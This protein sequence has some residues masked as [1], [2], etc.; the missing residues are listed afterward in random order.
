MVKWASTGP[1]R[2]RV[3]SFMSIPPVHSKVDVLIPSDVPEKDI[4]WMTKLV[5][6]ICEQYLPELA[7]YNASLKK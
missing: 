1:R 7:K 2:R 3:L 5:A 6:S 4:K